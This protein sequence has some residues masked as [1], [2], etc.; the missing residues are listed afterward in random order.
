MKNNKNQAK[1]RWLNIITDDSGISL[2]ELKQAV[3]ETVLVKSCLSA[4]EEMEQLSNQI[5]G[6]WISAL[7]ALL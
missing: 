2:Q 4:H 5:S 6:F 3:I 1:M 7:S